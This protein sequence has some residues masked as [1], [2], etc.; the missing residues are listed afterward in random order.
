MVD[1]NETKQ[2]IHQFKLELG[3]I[4]KYIRKHLSKASQSEYFHQIQEIEEVIQEEE[5]NYEYFDKSRIIIFPFNNI[6]FDFNDISGALESLQD[7]LW[8]LSDNLRNV[9]KEPYSSPNPKA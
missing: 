3:R 4:K 6:S 9:S 7:D 2:K 1:I 8:G 5:A